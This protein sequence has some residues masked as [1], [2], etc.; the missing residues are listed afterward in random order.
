MKN[1]LRTHLSGH[2]LHAVVTGELDISTESRLRRRLAR[3]IEKRLPERLML[4]LAGVTFMDCAGLSALV[5]VDDQMRERGGHTVLCR[6]SRPVL[7]VISL[8]GLQSR[9]AIQAPPD[10][11]GESAD[12]VP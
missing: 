2:T 12:A 10:Q 5:W 11:A 9:F 1:Q 3:G 4:D 6:P 8:L 7:K